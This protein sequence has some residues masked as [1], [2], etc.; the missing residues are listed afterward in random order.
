M[1]LLK[2]FPCRLSKR[3][4]NHAGAFI[5]DSSILTYTATGEN[6]GRK[7]L[8]PFLS[9]PRPR[10]AGN[11]TH[12]LLSADY[13]THARARSGLVPAIRGLVMLT[14]GAED[15]VMTPA[16]IS[17]LRPFLTGRIEIL[18]E[19]ITA[20]PRELFTFWTSVLRAREAI[21]KDDRTLLVALNPSKP[22]ALDV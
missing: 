16:S 10:G 14:D 19:Q 21:G 5:G 9:F 6:A 13:K 4:A 7:T 15:F 11:R 3:A 22:P 20:N 12:H 2:L 18:D 8:A 1:T 17:R